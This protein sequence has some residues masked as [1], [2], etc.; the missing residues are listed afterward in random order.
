MRIAVMDREHG[1]VAAVEVLDVETLARNWWLVLLRGVAGIIFGLGTLFAPGISL[2]VLVLFFGAYAFVDGILALVSVLR[3]RGTSD[4]WW[5]L[6]L[7]GLA[8]I[9]AGV[10]TLLW[11]GISALALLY[12]IAAWALVTGGF[13]IAAAIRLRKVLTDEWLFVLSGIL[14]VALGVLLILF[15]GP[16]ALALVLWIGAYSLVIGILLIALG[17]R[18]RSWVRSGAAHAAHAASPAGAAT[19]ECT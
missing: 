14:S 3:R 15:P 11:P 10:V 4:P 9:A 13:E 7:E 17:L 16:G 6:L 8:G 12:V 1:R 5:W 18:L 19:R 2:L